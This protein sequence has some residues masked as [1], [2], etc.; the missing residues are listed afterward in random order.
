MR[1]RF[2]SA[3]KHIKFVKALSIITFVISL[4]GCKP[5]MMMSTQEKFEEIC[6]KSLSEALTSYAKFSGWSVD[7][8]NYFDVEYTSDVEKNAEY[9]TEQFYT[10]SLLGKGAQVKNG[11]GTLSN[12]V[13]ECEGTTSLINGEYS[14]P[15]HTISVAVK[16]D[17]RR[18]DTMGQLSELNSLIK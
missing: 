11:F 14:V 15:S 17:G 9:K 7:N 10:F 2:L 5:E 1:N 16:L 3:T 12:S 18:I 8:I 6:T 4:Q 13:V